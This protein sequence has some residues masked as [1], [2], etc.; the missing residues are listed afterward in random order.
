MENTPRSEDASPGARTRATFLIG[1]I[2]A[3]TAGLLVGYLVGSGRG[4]GLEIPENVYSVEVGNAPQI[5]PASAPVT[6]VIFTDFQCPFCRKAS[7]MIEKL[8]SRYGDDVRIA[9]KHFPMQKLHPE[10]FFAHEASVGASKQGK[11]WAFHDALFSHQGPLGRNELEAIARSV[12][13]DLDAFN[14]DLNRRANRSVVQADLKQGTSLG[15]TGTPTFFINGRRVVGANWKLIDAVVRHEKKLTDELLES[16]VPAERIYDTIMKDALKALED[17]RPAPAPQPK[18]GPRIED[19]SAVYRVKLGNSTVIGKPD[20]PVTIVWFVDYQCP[21]SEKAN[22]TVGKLLESH[23]DIIRLVVKNNPQPRH[24]GAPLAAEAVLAAGSQGK[25]RAMHDKLFENR[26]AQSHADLERYAKDLGLDMKIFNEALD[27]HQYLPTI[28]Q[29][30]KTARTL[31]ATSTPTFFVNGLK[32]KGNQPYQALEE[33][34]LEAKRKAEK[35]L[36][37]GVNAKDLYEHIIANG[38]T[39]IQY[40]NAGPASD[41]NIPL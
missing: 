19:P 31:G 21:F 6:V 39:S 30:Q 2:V 25:F 11:F 29:E 17:S 35:L 27:A 10:I 16:G 33:A 23:G 12:G 40:Q 28:K 18:P 38:A 26:Q 32:Y 13:L 24:P 4:A 15:V 20:A 8:R 22:V 7:K 14:A 5:G 3:F 1:I 41:P 9:F 34:V 37:S 36:A